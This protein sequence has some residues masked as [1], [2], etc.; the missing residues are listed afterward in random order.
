MAVHDLFSSGAVAVHQFNQSGSFAPGVT[1]L[2][3]GAPIYAGN[4][5]YH[6]IC[7][8]GTAAGGAAA[9][10]SLVVYGATAATGDGTAVLGS[11]ALS[12]GTGAQ[13]FDL[14]ADTLM[15]LGTAYT[16]LSAQVIVAT[17]SV[18]VRGAAFVLSYHPRSA[19]TTPAA[20]G[21]RSLGTLYS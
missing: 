12:R 19:G 6:A 18:D 3:T 8:V 4:H 16:H 11:V 13:V 5:A 7:F 9:V 1:D 17:G 2:G 20:A 21:I 15:G 14:K 10:G